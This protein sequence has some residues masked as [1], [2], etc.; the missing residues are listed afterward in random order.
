MGVAVNAMSTFTRLYG[1]PELLRLTDWS[2]WDQV[3]MLSVCL[4]VGTRHRHGH[5]HR[6]GPEQSNLFTELQKP[7]NN[8]LF[9][10][11][12]VLLSSANC[13]DRQ[14]PTSRHRTFTTKHGRFVLNVSGAKYLGGLKNNW[15][16]Q[17][18]YQKCQNPDQ[19]DSRGTPWQ[20]GHFLTISSQQ[21]IVNQKR[22][23]RITTLLVLNHIQSAPCN[24]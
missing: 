8:W 18:N 24:W 22:L 10:C 2:Y 13:R 3:N 16:R 11:C 7:I 4:I 12:S 15:N 14:L 19:K 23:C 6:H 5:R 20:N 17:K 1:G 21:K 9:T